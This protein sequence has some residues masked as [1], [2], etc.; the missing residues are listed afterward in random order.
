[1]KQLEHLQAKIT[2][3]K[4]A[5]EQQL[6]DIAMLQIELD[7]AERRCQDAMQE[8]RANRQT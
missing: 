6:N 2:E 1:M 4:Q 8:L 5:L 3:K 7:S